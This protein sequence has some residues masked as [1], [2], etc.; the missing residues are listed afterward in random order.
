MNSAYY[1]RVPG[2]AINDY[3]QVVDDYSAF[4]E[5]IYVM[6]VP[7]ISGFNPD[8]SGLDFCDAASSAIVE[9]MMELATA[10]K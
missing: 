8:Y 1:L 6:A 10:A 9:G 2:I 5:R 3:F 4:N 7:F